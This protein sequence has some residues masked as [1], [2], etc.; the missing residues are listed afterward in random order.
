MPPYSIVSNVRCANTHPS[1]PQMRIRSIIFLEYQYFPGRH[2]TDARHRGMYR[3]VKQEVCGHGGPS[4]ANP[5]R[6]SSSLMTCLGQCLRKNSWVANPW[7][8][9]LDT[10]RH[11]TCTYIVIIMLERTFFRSGSSPYWPANQ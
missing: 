4:G 5:H 11:Y 8:T 9:G 6:T 10:P 7:A 3:E 1:F 2:T